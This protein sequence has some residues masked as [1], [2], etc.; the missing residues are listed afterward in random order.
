[1]SEEKS[2]PRR[3]KAFLKDLKQ[4]KTLY[5][6]TPTIDPKILELVKL[7]MDEVTAWASSPEG[8]EASIK[9]HRKM[10]RISVEDL[11]RPFDI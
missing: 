3:Q 7:Q 2:L 11:F 8:R 1:M 4:R 5:N 10:S 6:E 9:M